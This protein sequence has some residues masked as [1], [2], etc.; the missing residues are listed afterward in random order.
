MHWTLDVV[1]N[2]DKRIAEGQRAQNLA[3]LKRMHLISSGQMRDLKSIRAKEAIPC[4]WTALPRNCASKS[5]KT[6]DLRLLLAYLF[7]RKPCGLMQIP[8]TA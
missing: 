5:I 7:M 1:L 6:D 2:E 3:V 8:L 4:S